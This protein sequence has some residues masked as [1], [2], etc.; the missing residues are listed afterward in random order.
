MLKQM[1]TSSN[2]SASLPSSSSLN[3]P[4]STNK[5]RGLF[6]PE[7]EAEKGGGM[8]TQKQKKTEGKVSLHPFKSNYFTSQAA[9]EKRREGQLRRYAAVKRAEQLAK[10]VVCKQGSTMKMNPQALLAVFSIKQQEMF[11]KRAKA[12]AD[13]MQKQ[14]EEAKRRD[15][16]LVVGPFGLMM[17]GQQKEEIKKQAEMTRLMNASVQLMNQ[18]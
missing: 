4:R 13:T 1:T 6:L 12:R 11:K 18:I 17:T 10:E 7:Q 16:S 15:V 3:K 14:A 2:P 8:D 5:I 9:T